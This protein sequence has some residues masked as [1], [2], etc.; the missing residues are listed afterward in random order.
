MVLNETL[1]RTYRSG[2]LSWMKASILAPLVCVDSLG[3]FVEDWVA[4][5][6]RV[7]VRRLRDD[8][9]QALL[10]EETDPEAFRRGGGR[11]P[12]VCGEREIGAEPTV[13]EKDLQEADPAIGAAPRDSQRH[14]EGVERGNAPRSAP[15]EVCSARFIG[16]ADIVQLFRA[17]LCTVRRRMERHEGRLPTEGEALGAMLDHV[18]FAWGLD[19]KTDV[20]HK[21]FARDGWRC[22]VPGCTSMRNLHSHHIRFRSAE[23]SDAPENRITLCAFH[24]LRGVHAGRVRCTG[25]A[26][27][28]LR[29]E[30]GIR[31]GRPPLLSYSSGD[32]RERISPLS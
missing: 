22:A 23:G 8:V 20:R 28:G 11:P 27:D 32:V 17:V 26:P 9:E 18:F 2:E 21:V 24:H 5:A 16:P 14:L 19:Q 13:W 1:A 3:W 6:G 10:L 29:W 15:E 31:P 4:W 12:R 30:M 25:R 7:T